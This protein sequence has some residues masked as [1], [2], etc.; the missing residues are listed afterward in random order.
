M[1]WVITFLHFGGLRFLG[2]KDFR[3]FPPASELARE[4]RRA[5]FYREALWMVFAIITVP[6]DAV[7]KAFHPDDLNRFCLN[8]KVL[9]QKV[10]FFKDGGMPYWSVFLEYDSLLEPM[11][12]ETAGLTQVGKLCYEKLRQWRKETA[13]KDGVPPFVIARNTQLSEIIQKEITTMEGLKQINGFGRKKIEKYGK[14]IT[15]IIAG[16]YGPKT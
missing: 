2:F 11:G 16:F 9:S 6:F 13:E 12:K 8:K 1:F 10:E 4:A 7:T 5:A 3:Q 14:E 15:G